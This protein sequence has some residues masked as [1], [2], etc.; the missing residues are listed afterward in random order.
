MS[1]SVMPLRRHIPA[2]V[3]PP[4]KRRKVNPKIEEITFNPTDRQDYLSGFHKRKVQRQKQA[5]A[6][7]IKRGREE[8]LAARKTVCTFLQ[9]FEEG[10]ADESQFLAP[11]RAKGKL[12][13]SCTSCQRS[14]EKE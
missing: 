8:K 2:V 14:V 9:G 7:A 10:H 13:K 3:P 6:E 4:K 11:R 5:Q 12:A 1:L